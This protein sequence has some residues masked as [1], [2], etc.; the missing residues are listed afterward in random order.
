MLLIALTAISAGIAVAM[1]VDLAARVFVAG[2]YASCIAAICAWALRLAFGD[3][4]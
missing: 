2:V 4:K 1:G 3:A